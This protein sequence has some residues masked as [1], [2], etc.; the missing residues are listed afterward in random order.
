M[1]TP[2]RRSRAALAAGLAGLALL[3]GCGTAQAGDAV[4]QTVTLHVSGLDRSYL[5]SPAHGDRPAA[6]VVVVLHQEGGTPRGVAAETALQELRSVGITLAYPAGNDTSWNAGACCGTPSRQRVDDPAFLDAV[7]ADASQRGRTSGERRPKLALVG[8]SSGG[9][10]A[11]RYLCSR[12]G[13]GHS[14]LAAAIIVSGTLESA[15]APGL[16]LPPI[17]ALQGNRD[18]TVGL[19][20]SLFVRPLGLAPLPAERAWS[21]LTKDAGCAGPEVTPVSGGA[22]RQ[23]TGCAGG[24]SFTAHVVADAGHGWAGLDASRQSLDFLRRQLLGTS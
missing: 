21:I 14:R 23:W 9:M 3:A 20:R 2:A 10:L 7:F 12:R 8:Y 1:P 24:G 22:Q 6:A 18:G 5:L 13:P 16:Q 17:L 11:Y 15:C 19:S 4:G